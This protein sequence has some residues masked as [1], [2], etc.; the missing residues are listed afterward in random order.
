MFS[1]ANKKLGDD[2]DANS[3]SSFELGARPRFWTYAAMLLMM[4][5]KAEYIA[6]SFPLLV[7]RSVYIDYES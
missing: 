7:V 1:F 5:S 4:A 3:C 2:I 6:S